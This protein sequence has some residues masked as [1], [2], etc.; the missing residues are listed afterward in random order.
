LDKTEKAKAG[1]YEIIGETYAKMEFFERGWN[2]YSRFL[3]VDKVD[4][5]LRKKQDDQSI[6]REVQVKFG[7]LYEVGTKFEKKFFD[8]TSWRFFNPNEFNDYEHLDNFY[9]AYVLSKPNQYEGDIFIFPIK[10]FSDLLKKSIPS[11]DKVKLYISHSIHEDKWYVRRL[12]KFDK[13]DA[14]SV[15]EVTQY[16]RAFQLI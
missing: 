1:H 6:Y 10:F 7:R 8:V 12:S 15:L 11:K 2:P 16:R 14:I 4:L 13:L 5:I 9:V 3:D